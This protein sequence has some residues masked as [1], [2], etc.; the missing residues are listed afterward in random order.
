M[1]AALTG[2]RWPAYAAIWR[3]HFYAGLLCIPFVL[4]LAITGS[5]YVWRPQI[6]AW[7]D[8]PFAHVVVSGS[9]RASEAAIVGAA[10]RAVP[11]SVLHRFVLPAS[12]EQA[13]QVL[14][15]QG[16]DETRVYVQ[17]QNLAVL[18][19]VDED[20]RPMRIVFRLHG[21]LL[22]GDWGS[23][24]V[25][26]AAS[27]AIVMIVSG[28][29]LW[30]PRGQ[31]LA[32][33][34][35]P[36][37]ALRG[38]AWWRDVHGVVGLWVSL[39]ALLFLLSGLPWAKSWGGYLKAARATGVAPVSQD[40][41][42]SHGEE[43]RQRALHDAGTR[44][45]LDEHAEHEGMTM[46]QPRIDYV[47]LDRIAR[48][49]APL[50]LAP[51]VLIAPPAGPGAPWTA[52]SDAADRPLRVDLTIDRDGRILN[53]T[54]FAQRLLLDRMVGTGVA[55]HEGQL[56]GLANQ[57][58]N[59]LVAIGLALLAVS[60]AMMWWKRRP[61]GTLG[62]PPPRGGQPLAIGFFATLVALGLFLPLLGGSMLVVLAVERLVLRRLPGPRRWLGLAG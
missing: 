43:V 44:A 16:K 6:E 53:R 18:K 39:F 41:T 56:F 31:G 7:L 3:W 36:R 4:W 49:V 21:E 28:L 27:W 45:M 38:R 5:I 37:L 20:M 11:G 52:K 22:A 15:G 55:A 48:T 58:L 9:P 17:P 30:W 32:G 26:L 47:P 33:T 12:D 34:L 13:V 14:V 40:W 62:A 51:P 46:A 59:L 42:T 54:D 10:V 60:G 61:E 8:R 29:F 57:L 2:R 23:Y 50:S 1:A 24:V 35:Y 25:E 19:S